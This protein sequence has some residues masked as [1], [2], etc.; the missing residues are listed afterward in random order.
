MDRNTVD[1][2]LVFEMK[3]TECAKASGSDVQTCAFT[4]GFF[5]V[6]RVT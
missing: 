6:R 5:V 2:L 3:E 4:R 1:L